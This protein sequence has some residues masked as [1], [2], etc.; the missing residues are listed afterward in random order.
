MG[1]SKFDFGEDFHW[2]V[3]TA[4]Y[5]IE[6]AHNKHGKGMSIWDKFVQNSSK[7]KD[8]SHANIGCNFYE[9]FEKDLDM[10]QELHIPNYRFSIAWS[11]ILPNG[12][13]E[14]NQEGID[15]YNRLID[16]CLERNI[17]P[18]V[19]LYH[20]DLPQV[21][22]D[23]GGWTNREVLNWFDEFTMLCARSFGDRVKNWMVLNEP[24]VFTGAGYF[25]GYHAPGRKGMSNFLSA[26]HHA[27]LCQS[28]GA[29]ILRNE[30]EDANIGTTFSCSH[31]DPFSDDEKDMATATRFDGLLNRLFIEPALGIGYPLED[32]PIAK[33]VEKYIKQHDESLMH[34]DFDFIGVQNYTREVVKYNWMIPYMKGQIVNADERKVPLTTMNWEVYPESIYKVLKKFDAYE[35]VKNLIVTENGVAFPETVVNGRI[36]DLDRIQ[37]IQQY[38]NQVL[39]AQREGINVNGYFLWTLLD[40][41]EWAEGYTQR[42][43]LIH[44]NFETQERTIKDSGHWYKR[45]LQSAKVRNLVV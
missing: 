41:F 28:L 38:L 31:I 2:G 39:R 44:T 35:G 43:G 19:T 40:N 8:S 33:R 34:F 29:R 32:L 30:H 45:F 15:Y 5:Q 21:L 23:M 3:S 20:W 7:I 13:G 18:W 37:F 14:V 22:E 27:T 6:G 24:M 16:G 26:M 1:Y 36:K 17:T 11:R 25:L 12:I 4:A 42:F 9:H 10:I